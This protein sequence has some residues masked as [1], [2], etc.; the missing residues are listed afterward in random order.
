MQIVVAESRRILELSP[1]ARHLQRHG[2]P[3]ASLPASIDTYRL[4]GCTM[5][6]RIA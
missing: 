6:L 5:L 1:T 4:Y 2:T 3:T